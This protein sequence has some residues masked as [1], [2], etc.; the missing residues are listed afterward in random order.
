MMDRGGKLTICALGHRAQ[1]VLTLDG[2]FWL[3]PHLAACGQHTP[4]LAEMLLIHTSRVKLLFQLFGVFLF[5]VLRCSQDFFPTPAFS[6][7][8]M[9]FLNYS[10]VSTLS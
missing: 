2:T 5:P 7:S 1:V 8:L 3:P 4:L 6:L 10:D 9:T